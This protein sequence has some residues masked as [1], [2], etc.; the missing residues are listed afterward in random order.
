MKN[1]TTETS[2]I[3]PV[4]NEEKYIFPL[5]KSL[6]EQTYPIEKL[7]ILIIDGNSEDGTIK[8]VKKFLKNSALKIK[9]ISNFQ[10]IIPVSLNLGIKNSVGEFIVRLDAHSI[11]NKEYI[12][13]GIYLLKEKHEIVSVGGYLKIYPNGNDFRSYVVSK[14]F[15]SPFGTGP[16]KLKINRFTKFENCYNDTALYGMY[17]KKELI[18]VGYFNEKLIA[19]QD[20]EMYDRLKKK[21]DKKIYL[22]NSMKIDYIFKPKT[23]YDLFKRQ[24]RISSWIAKR[25]T[26]IRVRHIIPPIIGFI[27]ILLLLF[28]IKLLGIMTLIYSLFAMLFY[29]LEAKELKNKKYFPYAIYSFVMNHLG[30]CL[31]SIY[32]LYKN[33]KETKNEQIISN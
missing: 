29:L 10:K 19:T 22:S 6:E 9:I 30:Y 24:F 4:Y 20:I 21:F 8:E 17:R 31:G 7:E 18:E 5:L 26:G 2:V 15:S 23:G 14:V 32:S 1:Y 13:K 3:I 27:S 33:K 12:E 25:N 28:N 11:Y 16:S